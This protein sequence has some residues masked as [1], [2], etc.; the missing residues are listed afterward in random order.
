ML[1]FSIYVDQALF[2]VV[3][4]VGSYLSHKYY[5]FGGGRGRDS[6]DADPTTIRNAE[7]KD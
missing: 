7:S 4:V 3:V 2:L 5:S 1:P 6:G